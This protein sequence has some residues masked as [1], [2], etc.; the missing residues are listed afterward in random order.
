MYME[1][2]ILVFFIIFLNLYFPI[3]PYFVMGLDVLFALRYVQFI[4]IR[5]YSF[6]II[7]SFLLLLCSVV[8]FPYSDEVE[9]QVLFKY[10]RTFFSSLAI[11]AIAQNIIVPPNVFMN[12]VCGAFFCHVIAIVAQILYPPLGVMMA[13]YFN[14]TR[15]I[16]FLETIQLRKLG[17]SGGYDAAAM[18][19]VMSTFLSY[20]L[21]LLKGKKI[22]VFFS[23]LSAGLTL[24]VSR[25]GI[26][27]AGVILFIFSI[28]S[29]KKK[30]VTRFVGLMLMVLSLFFLIE[31]VVPILNETNALHVV[32][33][34]KTDISYFIQ[35][36]RSANGTVEELTG[37]HLFMY[38]KLSFFQ[39]LFGAGNSSDSDIG[40]IQIIFQV[41]LI[42]LFLILAI[43]F[44][45]INKL[46]SY[47]K[48]DVD[49][50]VVKIFCIT[51][52]VILLIFNYKILLLYSRG[53]YE[54][55]LLCFVYFIS[56]CDQIS[57][58]PIFRGQKQRIL[59]GKYEG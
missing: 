40:Y 7:C 5:P 37:T 27:G 58:S 52:I 31:V 13:P 15:E 6:L 47:S 9:T 55:L 49:M 38:E 1:S 20:L 3:S 23:L 30:G 44:W 53:L 4:R 46:F 35:D 51:Y 45:M 48:L 43:H 57:F 56:K 36:Y 33:N 14:F 54:F 34:T 39:L 22:Y 42:G 11:I 59:R 32:S 10:A 17:L 41:G 2:K 12:I 28:F 24:F 8:F 26:I 19:L 18:I 16:S 50:R 25:T 29:L 21:F